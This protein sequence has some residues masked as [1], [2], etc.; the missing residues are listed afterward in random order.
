MVCEEA[1]VAA[2]I[3]VITDLIKEKTKESSLAEYAG[4]AEK[5]NKLLFEAHKETALMCCNRSGTILAFSKIRPERVRLSLRSLRLKGIPFNGM[6]GCE[7]G[8]KLLTTLF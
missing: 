7:D 4:I 3:R 5:G 8:S 1:G 2:L 6:S